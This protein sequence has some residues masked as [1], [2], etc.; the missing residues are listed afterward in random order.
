M[1]EC[2]IWAKI[3]KNSPNKSFFKKEC[4]CSP[5]GFY[6]YYEILKMLSGSTVVALHLSLPKNDF[7]ENIQYL[8]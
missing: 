2:S 6:G 1:L 4:T 7:S 3:K 5:E 8:P